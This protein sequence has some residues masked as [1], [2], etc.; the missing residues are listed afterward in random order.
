MKRLNRTQ[1]KNFALLFCLLTVAVLS[2]CMGPAERLW[3]KASDWGRAQ[4][5]AVS[6][7]DDPAP[8]VLDEDGGLY[9]L[10]VDRVNTTFRLRLMHFNRRAEVVWDRTYDIS[11]SAPRQPRLLWDGEQLQLFWLSAQKLYNAQVDRTGDLQ[12]EPIVLSGE[13]MI[14]I[15]D[16]AFHPQSDLSV[17]YAGKEE[18][19]G[20]FAL[21]PGNLE[22]EA[23]LVD[24][25][26]L[27]PDIQYD[28][29]GTL[30]ALW[31]HDD[32]RAGDNQVYYASYPHGEFNRDR[33]VPIIEPSLRTS[34][35][36]E[37]PRL[38]I[39]QE[40][41]YVLWTITVRT[42]LEAGTI[43]ASYAEFPLG[44]P[45]AASPAR[46]MRVP[47]AYDLTYLASQEW[48][49]DGEMGMRIPIEE[50]MPGYT[51]VVNS[52]AIQPIVGEELAIAARIR[53]NYLM[54]KTENQIATIFFSQGAPTSYQ[55][56][57]F[58]APD[59]SHPALVKDARGYS[60]ITW[61][62]AIG[63]SGRR[64]YLASTAPDIREAI[65]SLT[66][67]D[68]MRLGAETLFG[69]LTGA[70]LTPF[71]LM[72]L[73]A[74]LIIIGLTTRLR[75]E[76]ERLS[77]I[78]TLISLA[79]A[80]LAYWMGKRFFLPSMWEY[81]PFT[82]WIP[83]IPEWLKTPLR[84]GIPFLIAGIGLIIAWNYTY[85]RDRNS[86]LFFTLIYV[87][88]DGALTMAIYGVILLAAF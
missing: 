49:S 63:E 19:P 34:D 46:S 16:A 35:G 86:V 75:S 79:L 48:G 68:V 33:Q 59:S 15:Y 41:A 4:Q 5:V 25:I 50:G 85:R 54:R 12:G 23:Q 26:G 42:G 21:P 78:G 8:V 55:L 11:L 3:L 2:G 66:S 51:P 87:A 53:I 30:H 56:L 77:G 43:V 29:E 52:Y 73:I 18:T 22:G 88:V 76:D 83:I 67:D 14:E 62:E 13:A 7:V 71:A 82:S 1:R 64:V 20:L 81:V 27:S 6:Y 39:D 69:M 45:D 58:T 44:R 32:R 47:T 37:G 38:G 70:L 72:W 24:P 31:W 36:I 40:H 9:V 80:L 61:L 60:Y 65:G 28:Q 57:S 74:P 84:F 17:W 10:V